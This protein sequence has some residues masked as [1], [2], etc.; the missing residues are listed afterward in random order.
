MT[1]LIAL[2]PIVFGL[3]AL[4]AFFSAAETALTGASRA[5]MHQLERDG[6]R[7]ARRVNQLI[8]DQET[9]IGSVLLGN[10]LINI[11]ASA[12][13]TEVLTRAIPGALGVAI[14]TGLMTVLVLVFAEV[15]PKT[16]AILRSDDVARFLSAP[17]QVFVRFA[18]PII[19]AIQWVIRRTLGLFGVKL[20]M[21][22]DVLAAHEE[23]RGAV[24]YH[25]SEGLV[26]TRDR[27]MLGG[28]LD[29]AE[30]DVSE[31]MVH[32]KGISMIDGELSPREIV[33]EALE[34]THSRLPI[35]RDDPENIVGVLHAKD[36]LQ[37]L[38]QADGKIDAL[39]I[40]AI[41]REPW[42]IPETTTLKD[43]LAAFLK[44]QN[45]FA[46]V[47]DE[48]GA[49]KGLVT[50]EDILEEIVG[51]IED[52]HDIAVAGVRPGPDGAVMVDGSVTIRDLNRAMNWDL[53][54]D[55]AV[56]VAGL[57]IAEAQ[58]I[59]EVGQTF[60]FHRHQFQVA[61]RKGNQITVLQI[62]PPTP[63]EE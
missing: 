52:E 9:M 63:L 45:H 19:N 5:R 57:L 7:A 1:A 46:L 4:S 59:P 62:W 20:G 14:A 26:E 41:L 13:T 53:P 17:T 61:E 50:L 48:Y 55:E 54:D 23:I 6:D 58:R 36:L 31:V 35:Y 25:H 37:A 27:W 42:F 38:A 39:D 22:L 15:L 32:R 56:T 24:E 8:S 40:K 43:Q 51:E 12:L 44:R 11:L 60:T 47:V 21:E 29:L 34:S 30:M 16:L 3:L 18:G 28:V 2:G 33:E 49:L 10:N